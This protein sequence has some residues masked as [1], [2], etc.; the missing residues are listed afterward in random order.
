MRQ[1]D[2]TLRPKKIKIKKIENEKMNK[3]NMYI[4][5][6][7]LPVSIQTFCTPLPVFSYISL[8]Q[9]PQA[10]EWRLERHHFSGACSSWTSSADERFLGQNATA[11][12]CSWTV[13]HVTAL[14][15][16]PLLHLVVAAVCKQQVLL[17]VED[18]WYVTIQHSDVLHTTACVLY[19]YDT[20]VEIEMKIHGW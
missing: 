6:Q 8:L 3:Q 9:S 14:I 13:S 2:L 17:K 15:C 12:I 4:T 10:R 18:I 1:L 7:L 20:T 11:T 16:A 19:I 5:F